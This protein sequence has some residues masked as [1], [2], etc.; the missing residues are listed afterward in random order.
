MPQVSFA[1][2][3]RLTFVSCRGGEFYSF[4]NVLQDITIATTPVSGRQTR[5]KFNPRPAFVQ[6]ESIVDLA[7]DLELLF[8]TGY[9]AVTSMEMGRG[10]REKRIQ[11]LR[12]TNGTLLEVL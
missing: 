1:S 8:P 5:A 2:A 6:R 3:L 11:E 9:G 12:E 10:L 4:L 7:L